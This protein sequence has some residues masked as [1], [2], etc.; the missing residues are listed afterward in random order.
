MCI[1]LTAAMGAAMAQAAVP[2][3]NAH[4]ARV[5]HQYVNDHGQVDFCGLAKDPTDLR[6]YLDYVERVSPQ[7]MPDAFP[8][9][10]AALA[11][12]I[13]S[14]NALAMYNVIVSGTPKE[15]GWLT[16]LRFFG[17]RHFT[18]GGKAMTLYT[19]ENS[20]IRPMG[21]ER[22]HFALNCMVIGCPHLPNQPF[23][24]EHL[25]AQLDEAARRF[26]NEPRN[27]QV[28]LARGT[29]RVSSILN[30]YQDDF[31]RAS[32]TL[33]AYINRYAPARLPPGMEIEFIPYDWTINTQSRSC[34]AID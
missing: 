11:Y 28:N 15:L 16:R 18:I 22:V 13:N 5:L 1:A 2:D 29:V 21:D 23:S 34:Q 9:R 14:Y 32:P 12:Y 3:T 19:Y 6:A 8:T 4:W 30:F 33:L 24:G 20:V 31:L 7:N 27:L 17:G 10:G 25:D 26:F